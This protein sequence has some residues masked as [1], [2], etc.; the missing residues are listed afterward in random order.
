LFGEGVSTKAVTVCAA[1]HA[2]ES[3]GSTISGERSFGHFG[4]DTCVI[5]GREDAKERKN[6]KEDGFRHQR[7]I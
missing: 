5:L 3:I 4:G 7:L 6:D 1:F 2:F